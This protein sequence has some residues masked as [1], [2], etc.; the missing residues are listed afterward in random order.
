MALEGDLSL[1]QLSD[2]LQVVARQRKTGILTVQGK[3][4]ILAV[5][6]LA[7]E[8]V[9]ADALNQS[10]EDLLGEVLASRGT[11]SPQRFGVLAERQRSSGERLVDFLV[12][13]GLVGR[14]ELLDALR[15]LTYRLLVEVLRWREGQF[16]FYGG[17]EVAYEEGITPL[18]VEEVLMRALR[19]L[20]GEPG[21]NVAVPHGYVAYARVPGAKE[22]RE[23][24]EG[25]DD[26]TP[27]DPSV[28]WLTPEEAR[29]LE[30]LDGRT[31]AEDLA[32]QLG[33][34]EA[35][36]YFALHRLLQTG[37]AR[38]ASGV[39]PPTFAVPRPLPPPPVAPRGE[40]LRLERQTLVDSA[41]MPTAPRR[42][43]RGARGAAAALQLVLAVGLAVLVWRAPG[44]VLFATPDL[45]P[46]REAFD[47]LRRLSRQ[48]LV[49]R[50]AR[51]Y[52]LLEGRY[53][54]RL[55]EL[56]ERE[57]LP[58]RAQF[59]LSGEPFVIRASTERYYL[60]VASDAEASPGAREGVYGD[61]LLDRE[62]FAGLDEEGG[63]PLVL[64]D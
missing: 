55:D 13:Q 26:A 30:R 3:S 8:I 39:E 17:E 25:S 63:V 32:R 43:S 23:I 21:R 37:L 9:A 35:K 41:T 11:V 6:F 22:V 48:D 31:S 62:L 54:A 59:D 34:D 47:R 16:K 36:S 5:S 33:L 53:P 42:A 44:H 45:G 61:F 2:V 14:E 52:H 18:R 7:G 50:A 28:A 58:A 24:P 29:L 1:F 19:E 38:P 4:D 27:L 46:S 20:A 60:S 15:E 49:D 51:T 12:A 10:F 64:I 40:A 56:L 57:L